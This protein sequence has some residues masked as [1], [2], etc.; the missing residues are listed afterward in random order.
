MFDEVQYT[1]SYEISEYELHEYWAWV[2][3][4]ARVINSLGNNLSVLDLGCGEGEV[5]RLLRPDFSVYGLDPSWTA[6]FQAKHFLSSVNVG[7]ANR[8][9]Y[10]DDFYDVVIMPSIM[11]CNGHRE[12]PLTQS[13][14]VEIRRVLKPGGIFVFGTVLA[15]DPVFW[16]QRVMAWLIGRTP[17]PLFASFLRMFDKHPKRHSFDF[18]YVLTAGETR[19]LLESELFL[20]EDFYSYVLHIPLLR[21]YVRWLPQVFHLGSMYP[22]L[23]RYGL[24]LS[25]LLDE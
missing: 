7:S 24:F 19:R 25:R 17:S 1:G 16:Y 10:L 5:S 9:P 20:V 18:P 14:F 13:T 8:I 22:M 2:L 23:A 6:L 4:Q 21:R 15:N 11:S 3:Q 12:H